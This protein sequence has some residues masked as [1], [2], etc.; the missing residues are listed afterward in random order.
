MEGMEWIHLFSGSLKHLNYQGN[1]TTKS[2]TTF[3]IMNEYKYLENPYELRLIYRINKRINKPNTQRLRAL[4]STCC[5]C[6]TPTN[7]RGYGLGNFKTIARY[8]KLLK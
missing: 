6:N 4:K 3:Y 5:N 7:A 8:S 1:S 2:V